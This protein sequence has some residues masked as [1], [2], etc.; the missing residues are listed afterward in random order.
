MRKT[1]KKK[2][3]PIAVTVVVVLYIGPLVL[4]LLAGTGILLRGDG[5]PL[6]FPVIF[7]IAYALIGGAVI[8]GV[9]R[10]LLQRL[11]EIDG[12]EEEEASQY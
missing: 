9:I 11:D 7:L 3:A 5:S 6:L 8:A 4:A 1:T 12:G 10:A 2:I